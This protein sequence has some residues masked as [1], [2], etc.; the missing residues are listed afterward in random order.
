M[1]REWPFLALEV[2]FL[3][4]LLQSNAPEVWF[5]FIALLVLLGWRSLALRQRLIQR[6]A[7]AEAAAAAPEPPAA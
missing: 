2:L 5:W 7:T 1:K 3:V 6:R 4:V